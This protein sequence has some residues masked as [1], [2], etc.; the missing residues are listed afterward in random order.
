MYAAR[1]IWVCGAAACAAT[2]ASA[3]GVLGHED[4]G[5]E[6]VRSPLGLPFWLI[7]AVLSTRAVA[8][9]NC[10]V[11]VLGIWEDEALT[12]NVGQIV[13]NQPKDLFVGIKFAA[14]Y[15]G[16]TGIEFSI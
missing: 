15:D 16:L 4:R 5:G 13:P 7:L 9:D 6:P 2:A 11:C 14:A 8:V 10:F 12:N 1:E 3:N